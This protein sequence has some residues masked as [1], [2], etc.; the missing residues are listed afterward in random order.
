M[1]GLSKVVFLQ[2]SPFK[3]KVS[4]PTNPL[5][6]A[7]RLGRQV[8]SDIGQHELAAR[9]NVLSFESK[10]QK[11]CKATA[12]SISISNYA[13]ISPTILNET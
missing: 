7:T 4:H 3:S 2:D 5:G 6:I 1:D 13:T 10:H 12:S 8:S 9:E 11:N